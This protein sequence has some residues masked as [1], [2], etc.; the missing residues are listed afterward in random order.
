[1]HWVLDKQS[2]LMLLVGHKIYN[3]LLNDTKEM[4][5]NINEAIK[6]CTALLKTGL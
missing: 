5:D 2:K 3:L 1:M 4:I 6:S